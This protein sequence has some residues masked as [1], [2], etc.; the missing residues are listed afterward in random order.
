M[1]NKIYI[2][3]SISPWDYNETKLTDALDKIQ[4]GEDITVYI[5]S[6]GGSVFTGYAIYNLLLEK[7]NTNN[8]T[9]KI[10]GLAASIASIIAQASH[11]TLIA[12]TASFLIHNPF[13]IAVG[14]AEAF[15]KEGKTLDEITNQLVEVYK[16]KSNLSDEDLKKIMNEDR[17]MNSKDAKKYKLVD[18]IFEPDKQEDEDVS[19]IA[20]SKD[21]YSLVAQLN[22]NLNN[23]NNN[24]N[25]NNG[26]K[27][28]D[29]ENKAD[30]SKLYQDKVTEVTELQILVNKKDLETANKAQELSDL[31]VNHEKEL[32]AKNLEIKNLKKDNQD[33]KTVVAKAEV[34]AKV[35]KLINEGKVM[36]NMK[37]FVAESLFD[38]IL[39]DTPA[40]DKKIEELNALPVNEIL[41]RTYNRANKDQ[42]LSKDDLYNEENDELVSTEVNKI[43]NAKN[44]SYEEAFNILEGGLNG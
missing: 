9:I 16:S 39:N 41:A 40:Y 7:K 38:K 36:P 14:D 25:N 6:P 28:M 2:F 31:T 20:L 21:Y 17:I 12:K 15:K 23:E 33:F 13:S 43:M 22:V 42:I 19:N 27:P 29:G 37:D 4:D 3:G 5:N 35:E 10:I 8:I 34:T 11:K 30:I 18:D 32:Q 26:E 1:S 24:L 44:A